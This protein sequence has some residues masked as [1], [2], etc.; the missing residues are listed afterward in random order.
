[1]IKCISCNTTMHGEIKNKAYPI[2]QFCECEQAVQNPSKIPPSNSLTPDDR[3]FLAYL[4]A[5]IAGYEGAQSQ[6]V[7]EDICRNY[8]E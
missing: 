5:V 7:A 6:K 3:L 2:C 8:K 1:M 4:A